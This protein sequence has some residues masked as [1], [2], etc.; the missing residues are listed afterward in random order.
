MHCLLAAAPP[1]GQAYIPE[2]GVVVHRARI[3]MF[4]PRKFC[5]HCG[6]LDHVFSSH[7]HRTNSD[8]LV[9]VPFPLS[10]SKVCVCGT[11]SNAFYPLSSAAMNSFLSVEFRNQRAISQQSS[12]D[13]VCDLSPECLQVAKTKKWEDKS[14]RVLDRKRSYL[15]RPSPP[16][17]FCPSTLLITFP[18]C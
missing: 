7:Q 17:L 11:I 13:R 18:N 9:I 14:C 8:K 1:H 5:R 2:S 3:R 16:S 10:P 6:G 4:C 12:F 15:R